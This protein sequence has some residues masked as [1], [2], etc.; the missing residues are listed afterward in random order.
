MPQRTAMRKG[1]I[2][3]YPF[4]VYHIVK[5]K[6]NRTMI[7]LKI[8]VDKAVELEQEVKDLYQSIV[9]TSV[10]E[11][12]NWT[13]NDV[14]PA[15]PAKKEAPKQAEPVKVEAPKEEPK[16]EPV[17]EEPAPTVE[18]EKAV[19]SLEAT[20]EAVKDVMAKAD[21]KTKAKGEFKAFLDSIGAEKVTSAT[22]EQRIQI[23]EWVNSRG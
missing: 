5:P 10:K 6:G 22:D 4:K 3:K 13:T 8:T 9:G 20:R 11:V 7:E 14:K 12:E 2:E 21:D 15:K 17:K 1:H 16:S 23:M 19:P 18:P